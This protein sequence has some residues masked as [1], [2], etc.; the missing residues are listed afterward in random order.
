[1]EESIKKE[2]RLL[3][4]VD[5]L[6]EM[7]EIRLLSESY[8]KKLITWAIRESLAEVR[9]KICQGKKSRSR[10]DIIKLVKNA[11][12]RIALPSLKP[13][14]NATGIVLHTNLSRAPLG[15]EIMSSIAPVISGYSNLEFNLN[16]GRRGQR[17]DHIISLLKYVTG[18]ENTVVVNNN[19][20]AVLLTL[21]TFA[22]NKEVIVSRG[23]LIEI[24]GSF[25]I[26]DIMK[27]S[28]AK[29][30]EVGTTNRTRLADYE[31]AITSKTSII[32]KAHK[33][34]YQIKGFSE[35]AEIEE[36]VDLA[37]KHDLLMYYDIGSGLLRKPEGLDLKQEPDI[38]SSLQKGVDILS[39]SGDKLL[40]GPQAGIIAGKDK[41]IRKLARSPLMRVLRVGKLTMA[42]LTSVITAYLNDETLFRDLPVFSM[43]NRDQEKLQIIAT[44]LQKNL[45]ELEIGSEIIPSKAQVGGGTLPD[46]EVDSFAVKIINPGQN[47]KFA[48]ITYK[49]L[50]RLEQPVLGILREGDLIFD[51][52]SLFENQL[53]L[54]AEQIASTIRT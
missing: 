30:V 25:R 22:K 4:G 21:I 18:A 19:A 34:N 44:E 2:L 36:L 42:A 31:N 14:I 52:L 27:A 33:S 54:L 29:M 16:T 43:L 6:L 7:E 53:Q 1:M 40:G 26:P 12:S 11:I 47:K 15:Q 24:G 51:V 50:L 20:A 5:A 46:H 13:V 37:K 17:N 9:E 23:E 41:L 8:G 28:G 3:P 45:L 35:E 32:F 48:E 39:F 10:A 49:K 38:R